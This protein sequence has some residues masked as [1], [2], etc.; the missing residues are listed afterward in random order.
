MG[1]KVLIRYNQ[2][3][4]T[5][6]IISTE[7]PK[8]HGKLVLYLSTPYWN[9]LDIGNDLPT[10]ICPSIRKTAQKEFKKCDSCQNNKKINK[11]YD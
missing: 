2:A 3:L 10:L 5:Q 1:D 6:N 4:P 11:K 8:I 9:G 7:T